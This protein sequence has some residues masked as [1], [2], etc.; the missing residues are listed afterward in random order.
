MILLVWMLIISIL[1]FLSGCLAVHSFYK[2]KDDSNVGSFDAMASF[3]LFSI[4]FF[5]LWIVK[6]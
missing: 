4:A 6:S 2:T 5:A 1:F 3:L